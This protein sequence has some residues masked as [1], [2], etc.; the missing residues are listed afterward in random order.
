MSFQRDIRWGNVV[1]SICW[2][3]CPNW[4]D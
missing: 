3:Y 2:W 1:Y 4:W